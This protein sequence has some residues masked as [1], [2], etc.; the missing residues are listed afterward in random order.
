[1]K[2]HYLLLLSILLISNFALAQNVNI[3]L[4]YDT[5]HSLYGLGERNY[6]T[7]TVEMFNV[8]RWGDT[9]F[10]IDMDYNGD[11]GI[12][13]AYWEIARNLRFWE[14]P[15]ALHLEYNGGLSSNYSFGNA[16]LIGAAYIWDNATFNQGFSI[17]LNYKYI[18]KTM[19]NRP[20][21]YQITAVWYLHFY[22]KLL[23]FTGF[24]DFWRQTTATGNFIFLSEPQ[25]WV[26][27]NKI[28]GIP[29]DFN[30]SLG[31]EVKLSW[32][33]L[34]K[35]GFYAIPTIGMKWTF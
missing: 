7:S 8:D 34:G 27:L 35:D 15:V 28:N 3:Q 21:N 18:E 26:N 20:H 10:F 31:S 24:A 17:S 29:N 1:M 11:K 22:N 5:R 16:Y 13:M 2:K 14:A 4:H 23:S 33:F 9:F 6:L 19:D 12:G 32:N 30:L 25:L